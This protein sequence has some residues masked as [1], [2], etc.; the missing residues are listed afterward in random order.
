MT[1]VT[2]GVYRR[3]KQRPYSGWVAM[4]PASTYARFAPYVRRRLASLGVREADLPDLCQEVFLVAQGKRDVLSAVDRPDLWLREICRRVA[5]GYRRRAFHRLEVFGCDAET[6]AE[7]ASDLDD[8][9]EVGGKLALLRRALNHLDDESR[10]L[11][12]LHDGG[13]M[14]LSA[15][16]RLV[17]HDRK[18]VR[19]RLTRARRRVSRWMGAAGDPDAGLPPGPPVR[20]T[21]PQSPFM[22]DQAARGRAF[23]CAGRELDIL[24]VSPELCSG[25][26]GNVTISDWRAPQI[27]PG[28]ID[29]VVRRA[30]Y[31]VEA[32]GGEIVYL[33]LIEPNVSPPP[34]EVRAKIVDA[35]EIVGP[36]FSTFAVVLLAPDAHIYQPILEGLMLLARPRFPMR[37]VTSIA[38]AAQWLCATAARGPGGPLT[39]TALTAAAEQVRRLDA[40]RQ[41]DRRRPRSHA[42]VSR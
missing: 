23:G 8:D 17:E 35:L 41:D 22:R 27:T 39:A 11:L 26:I 9:C 21:P 18:T 42:V 24:R 28:L 40:E 33:A 32:C 38:A 6:G 25:R 4:T 7:P 31:T 15:L 12:A 37:F 20:T 30:P 1:V 34:L 16:A 29:A 10:D 2:A 13:A 36:Y 19:S 3:G 5:S 14:P